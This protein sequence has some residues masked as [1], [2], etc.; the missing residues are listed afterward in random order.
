[1]P[2]GIATMIYIQFSVPKLALKVTKYIKLYCILVK[3]LFVVGSIL[4][5]QTG[6]VLTASSAMSKGTFVN[7]N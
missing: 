5:L 2:G 4:S 3:L 7:L 1:M 6:A